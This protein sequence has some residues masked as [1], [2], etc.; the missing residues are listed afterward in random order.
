MTERDIQNAI[1]E[2]RRQL[3]DAVGKRDLLNAKIINLEQNI[4]N[5]RDTLTASRMSAWRSQ[6]PEDS[7]VGLTEAIR[8]VLRRNNELMTAGEIRM[9]LKSV[10]FDLARFKNPTAAIYNTLLRMA[11]AGEV[12]HNAKAKTFRL[13]INYRD[14]VLEAVEEMRKAGSEVGDPL[15]VEN[16]DERS[17]RRKR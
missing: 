6:E 15:P 8:M 17:T 4:R 2:F 9:S 7:F 5:L 11:K 10:G 1:N 14:A 3:N 16:A 13:P 12:Q